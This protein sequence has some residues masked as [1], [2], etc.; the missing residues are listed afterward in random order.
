VTGVPKRASSRKFARLGTPRLTQ[1]RERGLTSRHRTES[2]QQGDIE[3]GA[4]TKRG[5]TAYGE[6]AVGRTVDQFIEKVPLRG[7]KVIT[8]SFRR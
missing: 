1:G 4:R 8:N 2:A 7:G 6:Q 3:I 5:G